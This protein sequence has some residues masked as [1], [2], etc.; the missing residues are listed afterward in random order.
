MAARMAEPRNANALAE[1]QMGDIGADRID[2]SDDLMSG[3]DRNFRIRQFAVN[4]MKVGTADAASAD[5][6]ANFAAA[7]HGVR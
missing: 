6:N 5:A 2:P 3:D 4:D 7:R 1:T